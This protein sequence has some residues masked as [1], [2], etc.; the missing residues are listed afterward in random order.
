MKV[1]RRDFYECG[2]KP[3]KQKAIRL[4]I[5]YLIICVFFLVY[6]VE[7]LFMFPFISVINFLGMYDIE[8]ICMFFACFVVSLNFDFNRHAMEWQY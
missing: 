6:D 5:Q 4:P 2:F 7:F 8:L 3:T 1:S